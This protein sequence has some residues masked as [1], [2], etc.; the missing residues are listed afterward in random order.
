[1]TSTKSKPAFKR[2]SS[3]GTTHPVVKNS[4]QFDPLKWWRNGENQQRNSCWSFTASTTY[5]WND[6]VSSTGV[7]TTKN[8]LQE[9]SDASKYLNHPDDK[10]FI[11]TA[12][13]VEVVQVQLSSKPIIKP[14]EELQSKINR[15]GLGY[16]KY[17]TK[18]HIPNYSKPI[19]FVSAGFLK[20]I[21]S[22]RSK[23]I[24]DKHKGTQLKVAG[25]LKYIHCQRT[26]HM[27]D[28][29]FDLHP[30][31]YCGKPNHSSENV[32]VKKN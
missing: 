16:F 18:L 26:G 5:K 17:D 25:K 30:C 9:K 31:R 4:S 13:S 6:W 2:A 10:S 15:R 7:T 27:V 19:K 23:K 24:V 21:T 22:A 1:M 12:S 14:W 8:E 11:Q 20:Q 32:V 29:F 3:D 28:Q